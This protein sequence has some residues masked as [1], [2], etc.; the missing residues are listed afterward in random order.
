M[1]ALRLLSGFGHQEKQASLGDNTT[2][3]IRFGVALFRAMGQQPLA[4]GLGSDK[5]L[6]AGGCDFAK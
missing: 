5:H 2:I 4:S 6:L 1:T 3:F